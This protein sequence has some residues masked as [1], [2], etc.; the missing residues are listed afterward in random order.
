[1]YISDMVYI[2]DIAKALDGYE[3]KEVELHGWVYNRRSSKKVQFIE[4]RDGTGILQC[5]VGINDVPP[6]VFERADKLAQE[7]SIV[8]R[9]TV[10]RDARS[11]LGFEL[12]ATDVQLVNAPTQEYPITPKEHGTAFLMDHRHLWLR[13]KRQHA[14]LRI[15]AEIVGAIRRFFDGRGF[16]LVDAPIFTPA[17]CE[18][19]SNLFEVGYFD[20]KAYLTQ[21]GQLYMEA[22]A[23]ALGKV[24]CFG[25]TF[26]A[27][28]SKTRRHL[29]EFWM[30]EP[31]VAYLE[32][33]G[34]MEL[35]EDLLVFVVGEVLA[36]RRKELV[37]LERDISK[38]DAVK[39]PF[40]RISYEEAIATLQKAGHP[41]KFGDD[42]G[43]DEETVISQSFDRP[44]LIHRYPA[45]IKAFYMKRD[46]ANEKLALGVDCI[47][48]EGY[49][50][51]I[52]GGQREDDLAKLEAS[53]ASHQLPREAFEW[54]LD[55]RRYGSVPHGGF[56][57]GVERTVAWICGLHHVR[58]TIPFP[59]MLE[60]L[61]P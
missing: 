2:E 24:Y 4:L 14:I 48:P 42:F 17:A 34:V 46:P 6:E 58:E 10:R 21:S 41:A 44:V 12:G 57:L 19:T 15:R 9:G 7:A 30:V 50:E 49:G 32:L 47:A 20:E 25:P 52:G 29:T 13:S 22:G 3:G 27:E 39:K 60:R 56:G 18:G 35:A 36:N 45:E 28:K 59:R 33:D 5:V 8:V 16:T 37:V 38:L 31:E 55:I 40:P 26:R 43:G 23:M 61:T 51:I 53:I 11:A 54:Y 1:V